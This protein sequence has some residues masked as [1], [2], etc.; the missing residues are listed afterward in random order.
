MLLLRGEVSVTTCIMNTAYYVDTSISSYTVE[1]IQPTI[2][3]NEHFNF[4]DYLTVDAAGISQR[5]SESSSCYYQ[6]EQYMMVEVDNYS[7]EYTH[8]GNN[9]I[10]LVLVGWAML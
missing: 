3:Y 10:Y 7:L 9:K 8:R 6:G 5:I 2:A 1:D 4:R